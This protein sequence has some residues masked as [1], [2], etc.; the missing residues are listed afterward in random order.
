MSIIKQ[1]A[2]ES[3]ESS[4]DSDHKKKNKENKNLKKQQ[5]NQDKNKRGKNGHVPLKPRDSS[6]YVDVKINGRSK[7]TMKYEIKQMEMR[8][9]A[10]IRKSTCMYGPSGTGK[11]V[12]TIHAMHLLKDT[13]PRVFVFSPTNQQNHDYD[14]IIPH[15]LIFTELK[16]DFIVRLYEYQKMA[17]DVY[18]NANNL[19]ILHELFMKVANPKHKKFIHLLL[20][21]K[22]KAMNEVNNTSRSVSEK[23]QREKEVDDVFTDV[24]RDAYKN[25]I[26]SGKNPDILAAQS[27]SKKERFS[28]KFRNYNPRV[29]VIFDDAM[30]EIGEM[31][32]EGKKQKQPVIQNFFYKG[33]HAHITSFYTFQNDK[34]LD[35]ELRKNAFISLFTNKSEAVSYFSR[36]SNGFGPEEKKIALA[37]CDEIFKEENERRFC[38]MVYVRND[39]KYKF[40]YVIA[41]EQEPFEMCSNLVRKYCKKIEKK[42]ASFDTNNKFFKK[43][44]DYA[45]GKI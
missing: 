32:K 10:F 44:N 45:L 36:S 17:T 3:S 5:E 22:K 6:L 9:G 35:S 15:A 19:D 43:F 23:R 34:G 20:E 13:F 41:E 7:E 4:E 16:L 1:F 37:A 8:P 26:S 2:K 11:T 28:L 12:F 25:V 42:G 40:Q 18:E 27:L 31:I 24:L 39:P 33:R 38:K 21:A 30:T 14:G 29:L